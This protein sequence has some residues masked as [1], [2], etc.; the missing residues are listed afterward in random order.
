MVGT[1][2]VGRLFM[3]GFRVVVPFD[4]LPTA[5]VR[6]AVVMRFIHVVRNAFVV[7]FVHVVRNA[8]VVRFVHVVRNVVVMR[9]VHVVRN[10]VLVRNAVV[11][12][13]G[14]QHALV[15]GSRGG[16]V[17]VGVSLDRTG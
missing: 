10:V 15:G 2:M 11:G 5:V 7:R 8:F 4:G 13:A 17:R 9:F 1:S 6:N 3:P 16:K 14:R 12:S